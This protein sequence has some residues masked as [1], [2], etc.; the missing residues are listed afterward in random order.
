MKYV[1]KRSNEG[2]SPVIATILMVAITVVL[3]AV[4][5]VLVSGFLVGTGSTK[6]IGAACVKTN[7]TAYK[8]AVTSADSGVDF[9]QVVVQIVT[10]DG[11]VVCSWIANFAINSAG[12]GVATPVGSCKHTDNGD[13]A[14]GAGDDFYLAPIYGASPTTLAGLTFKM[15][16]G[17]AAGSAPLS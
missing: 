9:T 6:N 4:L 11:T 1:R 15:S 12:A 7:A 14:F 2:V 16:G 8:C 17:G 13:S 10:G 3:A 5:Y